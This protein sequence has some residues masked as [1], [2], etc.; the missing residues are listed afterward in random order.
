MIRHIA[1]LLNA[2]ELLEQGLRIRMQ[3]QKLVLMIRLIN[4]FSNFDAAFD[5]R[6]HRRNAHGRNGSCSHLY[7]VLTPRLIY[8]RNHDELL[9][10]YVAF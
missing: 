5:R 9:Y 8:Y 2:L 1:L 6:T 3:G 10:R 4:R 7:L